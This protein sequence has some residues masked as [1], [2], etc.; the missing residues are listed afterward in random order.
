L[1][2]VFSVLTR[3]SPIGA[4]GCQGCAAPSAAR[5]GLDAGASGDYIAWS[6]KDGK[7]QRPV[8]GQGSGPRAAPIPEATET[9]PGHGAPATGFVS[10]AHSPAVK[11]QLTYLGAQRQQGGVG[12]IAHQQ[13]GTRPP[14]T[15]GEPARGVMMCDEGE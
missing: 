5:P 10:A 14:P 4:S 8:A 3:R 1:Q 11:D 7:Q 12:G 13:P 2:F 15:S 6:S 9:R